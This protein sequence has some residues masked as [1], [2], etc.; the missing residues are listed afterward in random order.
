MGVRHEI[1]TRLAAAIQ[2]KDPMAA[3]ATFGKDGLLRRW[4][5]E[6]VRG[7]AVEHVFRQALDLCTM[8][9]ASILER[10]SSFVMQLESTCTHPKMSGPQSH[11]IVA[12]VKDETI[13][14]ASIW[15]ML[16]GPKDTG[17]PIRR[18]IEDPSTLSASRERAAT[19]TIDAERQMLGTSG[20]TSA[21]SGRQPRARFSP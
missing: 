10:Q 5:G 1:A 9:V 12:D 20:V 6:D 4:K 17:D 14:F 21:P 2:A 11:L 18:E 15:T 13:A 3:A 19:A 8:R 7:P 16:F